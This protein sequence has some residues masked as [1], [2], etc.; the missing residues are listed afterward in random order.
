MAT[1]VQRAVAIFDAVV[2]GTATVAQ[3]NAIVQAWCP[4]LPAEYTQAQK[5]QAFVRTVVQ[6]TRACYQSQIQQTSIDAA[7][8][9]A[10]TQATTDIPEA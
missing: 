4:N 7:I 3:Q 5:A 9:S 6:H 10:A 1:Y 8:A 2:N